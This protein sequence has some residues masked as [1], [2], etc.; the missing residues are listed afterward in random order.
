MTEY[1]GLRNDQPAHPIH[2]ANDIG[3]NRYFVHFDGTSPYFRTA[4]APTNNPYYGDL[5]IM[6][7]T[8]AALAH[9]TPSTTLIP[10]R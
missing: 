6:E 10:P 8:Q 3:G 2:L 9:N 4:G 7:Q 1:S 5:I